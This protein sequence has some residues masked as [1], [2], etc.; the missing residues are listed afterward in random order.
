M[1]DHTYKLVELVGSSPISIDD[2]I[3]NAIARA[4][5][6]VRNMRWFEVVGTRGHIEDGKVA[7]FQ[8][9]LKVGFTLDD[10]G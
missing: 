9:T 1:T 7:H 4:G 3:R 8:V 10:A 5:K 2:A 6:T